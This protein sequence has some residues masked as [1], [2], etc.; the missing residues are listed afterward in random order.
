[1]SSSP[2]P[3]ILFAYKRPEHTKLTVEAL[4]RNP[5]AAESDLWIFADGPRGEADR[6]ETERT[7]EYLRGICGFRNIV[8]TEREEN[9]GLTRSIIT[10]VTEVMEESGRAIVV[11]DD[12]LTAPSF[13]HYMNRALD[14]FENDPDVQSIT[15]HGMPP[16]RFSVPKTYPYDVYAT[17]RV[18]VWGW[19]SWLDRWRDVDWRM[20]AAH[21]SLK[22]R[23]ER[24]ALE[25]ISHDSLRFIE[26]YCAGD[27]TSWDIPWLYDHYR[28][29]R[30]CIAPVHSYV[31]NIGMDGSGEHCGPSEEYRQEL[32]KAVADPHFME[33]AFADPEIA[34]RIRHF[35]KREPMLPREI[36]RLLRKAGL[37][38]T[39]G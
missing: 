29:R 24:R 25:Q 12:I 2:A 26:K 34:D 1:M 38:K 20:D 37:L 10:G 15:G 28:R 39:S 23:A 31:E 13:L 36:K 14:H 9:Y 27:I 19:G 33:K 3:V 11:E 32:G 21:E 6:D 16:A 22:N 18:N 17:P 35:Y 5:E 4:Q 7:R 8:F 30:L